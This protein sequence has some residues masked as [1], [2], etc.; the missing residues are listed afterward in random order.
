MMTSFINQKKEMDEALSSASV[1]TIIGRIGVGLI[2]GS[3]P[4]FPVNP[5]VAGGA[6]TIGLIA[7]GCSEM[8]KGTKTSKKKNEKKKTK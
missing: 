8:T 2:G 7:Y 5:G 3:A 4:L 1:S 6:L